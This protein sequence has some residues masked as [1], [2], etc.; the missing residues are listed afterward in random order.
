MIVYIHGFNSNGN[1]SKSTALREMFPNIEIYSPSYDSS[2]FN[3]IDLMVDEIEEKIQFEDNVL[4]I[5]C[6]L[7]GYLSQ[8]LANRY[9]SKSILLNPCYD[10]KT[11]LGKS[12]GKNTLFDTG[13]EYI[14]TLDDIELLS[15][16]N[17]E[18][19]SRKDI[20]ISV[21]VNRDDGLIPYEGTVEYYHNRP[22]KIFDKGGHRFE[23]LSDIKE[24]I[25]Q[26]YNSIS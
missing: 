12:L 2:D 17:I 3:S 8:Y 1:G 26:I 5:G 16:Y 14:L 15:K 18:K 6:S 11:T 4:F 7:G 13:K 19:D 9:D 10:P 24:D 25:T 22:V 20:N 21:F 23:N